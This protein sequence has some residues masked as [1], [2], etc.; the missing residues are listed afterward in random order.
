M[1]VG[2]IHKITDLA[3]WT[4]GVKAFDRSALPAGLSNPVTLGGPDYMFCLWEAPSVDALRDLLDPMTEGAST[5]T[6]FV[7][8]P[9]ATGT[10]GFP[11]I[12]AAA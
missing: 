7:I 3:R 6:Y 9:D 1:Y 11:K 2:V 4:E 12:H 10:I 5:N 8:D